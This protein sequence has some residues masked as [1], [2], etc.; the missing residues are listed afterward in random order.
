MLGVLGAGSFLVNLSA[1]V[2]NV[3]QVSLRQAVIP[4]HLQG[5]L[6]AGVLQVIWSGQLAGSVLGGALG[7]SVGLRTT[8][9]V[10]A[11]LPL[12][13]LV[14]L[15]TSRVPCLRDPPELDVPAQEAGQ[16]AR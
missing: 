4:G 11:A 10:A 5:R 3:N 13:G 12:A 7:Q 2:F 6:Q 16:A 1:I 8:L 9:F 15:V 14:L